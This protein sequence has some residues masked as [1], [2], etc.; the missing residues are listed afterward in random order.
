MFVA[1][2]AW[3]GLG[4]WWNGICSVVMGGVQTA[5]K[6]N[7]VAHVYLWFLTGDV[8]WLEFNRELWGCLVPIWLFWCICFVICYICCS[9]RDLRVDVTEVWGR[10][11][12][13]VSTC[14]WQFDAS[15]LGRRVLD[16]LQREYQACWGRTV[17]GGLKF[18][19]DVQYVCSFFFQFR[20]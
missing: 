16:V 20:Y 17:L 13:S 14:D 7:S 9:Y 4:M 18:L 11:K 6:E 1:K 5:S 3:G 8:C 15:G 10:N 19:G 12:L 2:W